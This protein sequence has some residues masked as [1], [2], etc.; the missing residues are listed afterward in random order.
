MNINKIIKPLFKTIIKE[1]QILEDK[2]NLKLE[3]TNTLKIF[4]LK[5]LELGKYKKVFSGYLDNLVKNLYKRKKYEKLS[6]RAWSITFESDYKTNNSNNDN[7]YTEF[8]IPIKLYSY[9]ENEKILKNENKNK[10][11][12]LNK[13]LSID[14]VILLHG[15]NSNLNKLHNYYHFIKSALGNNFCCLFINLPYHLN[16]TPP[17]EKSGERLIQSKDFETL[18][19]FHQAVV[20]IQKAIAVIEHNFFRQVKNLNI[21]F[22]ICGISLGAMVSTI[23]LA[24]NKK[25]TKGV[26]IQGGGNW[27]EIYWNS[28]VR[29]IMRGCF[30][31]K[32]KISRNQAKQF[33]QPI[34]IF[35][36]ELKKI[37]QKNYNSELFFDSELS[38][39]PELAKFPQKTWFL[40][41]PLTSAVLVDPDKVLMI[42]SKFDFLFSKNSTI[43]LNNALRQPKLYWL[44]NFH[45]SRVLRFK[46]LQELIFNFYKS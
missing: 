43:Q 10:E 18:E 31:D 33:Y 15:F 7:V 25:I 32:E 22:Y 28:L 21:K 34:N 8:F 6:F 45:T 4:E 30:I 2:N 29:V 26:L 17:G 16:R 38:N 27:D 20:D 44:N 3:D 41:D 46:K 39:Y 11:I 5:E 9:L 24:W 36:E 12:I 23:A 42:N 1:N 35:L 40:S 19:F 37:K 13:E 14:I